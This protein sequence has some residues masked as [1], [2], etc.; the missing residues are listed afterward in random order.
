VGLPALTLEADDLARLF[1]HH[2]V[3]DA[4]MRVVA[5]GPTIGRLLP[6]LVGAPLAT[7][8]RV[9]DPAELRAGGAVVLESSDRRIVLRGPV[10]VRGDH[11]VLLVAPG[12]AER[13]KSEFLANMSHELRTPLAG[14]LGLTELVLKTDLTADQR[15]HLRQAKECAGGLLALIGDILDYAKLDAGGIELESAP[16]DVWDVVGAAVRPLAFAAQA[17]GVEIVCRVAPD[18]PARLGGDPSRLRQI[19]G[20]LVGN[21]V[22]FSERGEIVV[23]VARGRDCP[24]GVELRISV[25]DE[26]IGIAP[27][28]QALV[29][30]AFAQ[31]EGAANRK[32]GGAGLGLATASRLAALMG[33]DI[34]VESTP[35]SG[36]TFTVSVWL[37]L[38]ADR[39]VSAPRP[40]GRVLVVDDSAAALAAM[41]EMLAGLDA[42]VTAVATAVT[43]EIGR[44]HV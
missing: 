5:C 10:L 38:V 34:I 23:A 16:F 41:G 9:A 32:H 39:F 33:G 44:A 1:P 4:E 19:L 37:S 8:L 15:Q 26:G 29:F 25:A 14:V 13:A 20:H 36:S 6:S 27:E 31:A 43:S 30:T 18:V 17:K 11:R 12:A 7:V 42:E 21:A 24:G 2:L 22:K 28:K 3:V 40:V 35:G